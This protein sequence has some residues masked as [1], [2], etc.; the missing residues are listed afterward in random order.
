[1]PPEKTAARIGFVDGVMQVD[2]VPQT[3]KRARDFRSSNGIT[4]YTAVEWE[5]PDT[6]ELRHSCPCPSWTN[7]KADKERTC[8]HVKELQNVLTGT[9]YSRNS[10]VEL[11]AAPSRTAAAP[12]RMTVFAPAAGRPRRHLDLG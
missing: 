6:G 4:I 11:T 9:D 10:Q 5:D 1:M 8:K 3:I 12:S 2:G 7:K